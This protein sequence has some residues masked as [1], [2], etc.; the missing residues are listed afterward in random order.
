LRT[1]TCYLRKGI[2]YIPTSGRIDEGYYR[3]LDPV[4]VAP[5]ADMP[6]L[7]A[8]LTAAIARGNPATVVRDPD[9]PS[10]SPVLK[11]TDCKTMRQFEKGTVSWSLVEKRGAFEIRGWKDHPRG[12]QVLDH[13]RTITL[14]TGSTV[15]NAVDRMIAVLQESASK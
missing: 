10:S 3:D 14:P 13:A 4:E 7:R 8:A 11:H 15:A 6:R 1:Y 5:V 2:V 12:G 9:D